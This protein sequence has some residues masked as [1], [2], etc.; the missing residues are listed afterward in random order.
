MDTN[1]ESRKGFLAKWF[2]PKLTQYPKPSSLGAI[3]DVAI[4]VA[5]VLS[6]LEA[7]ATVSTAP[8]GLSEVPPTLVPLNVK[9]TFRA[10]SHNPAFTA[11]GVSESEPANFFVPAGC[12]AVEL[13]TGPIELVPGTGSKPDLDLPTYS[14]RARILINGSERTVERLQPGDLVTVIIPWRASGTHA[15]PG[16]RLRQL[17]HVHFFKGDATS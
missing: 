10:W 1:L 11:A 5:R 3:D 9:R 2:A 4:S 12:D 15:V 14:G 17:V 6:I 13:L 8:S 7:L 16:G